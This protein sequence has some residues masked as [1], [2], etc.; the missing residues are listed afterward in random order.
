[1]E[2]PTFVFDRPP[3][4]PTPEPVH[5]TVLPSG[6]CV[7][8]INRK[9]TLPEI[10]TEINAWSARSTAADNTLW[11][12]ADNDQ[13]FMATQFGIGPPRGG[14]AR[15]VEM[16]GTGVVLLRADLFVDE[17]LGSLGDLVT[18]VVGPHWQLAA[19]PSPR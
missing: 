7:T 13:R 16:G 19:H 9:L 1:M 14:P 2:S 18:R 11:T 12:H 8:E 15:V 10:V 4:M 3:H 5:V 6:V 17:A